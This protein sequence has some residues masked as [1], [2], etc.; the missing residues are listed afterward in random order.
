VLNKN[1]LTFRVDD[2]I[3]RKSSDYAGLRQ[4]HNTSFCVPSIF[5]ASQIRRDSARQ[6]LN[7]LPS[8]S[9]HRL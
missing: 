4:T 2:I 3:F 5:V 9:L 8:E 7:E 6:I 1:A